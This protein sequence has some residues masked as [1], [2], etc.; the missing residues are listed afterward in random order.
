MPR[1]EKTFDEVIDSLN[2][3]DELAIASATGSSLDTLLQKAK[4]HAVRCVIAMDIARESEPKLK[5]GLAY[6]QAMEMPMREVQDYFTGDEEVTPD[7]PDT[8]SGKGD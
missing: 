3:Y 8:E 1:T 5:Y 7:E 6:K 4:L 2:G